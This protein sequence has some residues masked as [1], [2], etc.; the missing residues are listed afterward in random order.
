M[1]QWTIGGL[2][3]L[4][5]AVNKEYTMRNDK[6]QQQ[7]IDLTESEYDETVKLYEKTGNIK[8]RRILQNCRIVIAPLLAKSGK[9]SAVSQ[10]DKE[11]CP[12]SMR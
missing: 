12:E 8:Y 2:K 11:S 7:H 10:K 1:N 3:I 6:K 4:M 9:A 5:I